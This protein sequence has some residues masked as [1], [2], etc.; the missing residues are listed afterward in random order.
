MSF[1][2]W[3]SVKYPFLCAT[4][5]FFAD[6]AHIAAY[7]Q[8][9]VP[10]VVLWVSIYC[11]F[12]KYNSKLILQIFRVFVR[13]YFCLVLQKPWDHTCSESPSSSAKSQLSLQYKDHCSSK[14]FFWLMANLMLF[15]MDRLACNKAVSRHLLI[16]LKHNNLRQ[17]FLPVPHI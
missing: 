13:I 8:L 10:E 9:S 4:N 3:Q 7:I 6:G 16:Q 11:I 5:F 2:E 1:G 12:L 14:L 17:I 15:P